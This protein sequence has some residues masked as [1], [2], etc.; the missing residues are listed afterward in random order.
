MRDLACELR[1][2][3]GLAALRHA[4]EVEGL[5]PFA[6][7][8]VEGDRAAG[9]LAPAGLVAPVLAGTQRHHDAVE[10][11]RGAD[12]LGWDVFRVADTV[13]RL[14][15]QALPALMHGPGEPLQAARRRHHGAHLREELFRFPGRAVAHHHQPE[16]RGRARQ[17]VVHQP[18]ALVHRH[19]RGAAHAVAITRPPVGHRAE[20]AHDRLRRRRHTEPALPGP[21]DPLS[22]V[23]EALDPRPQNLAA[24]RVHLRLHTPL[25]LFERRR[26]GLHRKRRAAHSR[27][28]R[29]RLQNPSRQARQIDG[30]R[31][32]RLRHWHGTAPEVDVATAS[33]PAS[34][35]AER[36]RTTAPPSCDRDKCRPSNPRLSPNPV[37]GNPKQ[38]QNLNISTGYDSH[39]GLAPWPTR[40]AMDVCAPDLHNF[41]DKSQAV[42]ARGLR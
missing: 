14:R 10:R 8:V 41:H 30:R 36:S 28:S 7:G 1:L 24:Q 3:R 39:T 25:H 32:R 22:P 21:L 37:I 31:L 13:Q 34:G 11:D 23:V 38:R 2:Q 29:Q 42:Y 35:G 17:P 40:P 27:Q 4:G 6:L 15:P 20:R 5:E 9:G 16:P 18:Q 12:C 26:A 33:Y 19:E